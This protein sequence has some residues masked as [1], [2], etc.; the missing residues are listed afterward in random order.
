[1]SE[2]ISSEDLGLDATTD[3]GLFGWFLASLLFGRPIQQ[4]VAAQTWRLL[5]ED[6]FTTPE[7]IVSA[8][9]GKLD[10]E[11]WEGKYRRLVG[12]MAAE[13]PDVMATVV[14][15]YGSVGNLVRTSANAAELDRRL[16]S[17]KGVGP[18]TAEIFLRDVPNSVIGSSID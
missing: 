4:E 10:R 14:G 3:A 8:G 5:I 2:H 13:L 11:L 1:M 16:Q 18:K 12:V 6:G 9:V 15:S 7:A 17:F